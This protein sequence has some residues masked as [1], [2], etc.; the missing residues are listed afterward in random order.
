MNLV[1]IAVVLRLSFCSADADLMV[2]TLLKL[3]IREWMVIHESSSRLVIAMFRT[4]VLG[5]S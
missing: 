1:A 4:L 2:V 5:C 3:M